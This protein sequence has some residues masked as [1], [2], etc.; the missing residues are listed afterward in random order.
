MMG[1]IQALE[2]LNQLSRQIGGGGGQN[3]V[4]RGQIEARNRV[5][6]ATVAC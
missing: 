4:G 2:L 5:V 3:G 1:P 6:L